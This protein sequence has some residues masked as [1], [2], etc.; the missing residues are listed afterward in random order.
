M[1][2][3]K[4]LIIK[5]LIEDHSISNSSSLKEMKPKENIFE[6]IEDPE[7]NENSND[8][9]SLL[10]EYSSDIG[11]EISNISLNEETSNEDI[12]FPTMENIEKRYPFNELKYSNRNLASEENNIGFNNYC[13]IPGSTAC[14]PQTHYQFQNQISGSISG[15]YKTQ[16][17]NSTNPYSNELI[18]PS[19]AKSLESRVKS[20][21]TQSSDA[22]PEVDIYDVP[23]ISVESKEIES[24]GATDSNSSNIYT[25]FPK[26]FRKLSLEEKRIEKLRDIINHIE[27]IR[28]EDDKR[29]KKCTEFYTEDF[30]TV[31]VI[32]K[33]ASQNKNIIIQ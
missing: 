21:S 6:N 13:T 8:D 4:E 31:R 10:E 17:K 33:Y 3:L 16:I 25:S 20:E 14:I 15:S 23:M 18:I 9:E 24:V 22:V 2:I 26:I 5:N 12:E 11:S 28:K 27:Y 29:L 1:I 32:G 30:E 7:S 19:N